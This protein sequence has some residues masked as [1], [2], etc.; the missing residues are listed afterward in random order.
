M[1]DLSGRHALVT[2]SNAGIG[3]AA[4]SLLARHG[5]AV[6][7]CARRLDKLADA[8]ATIE[9]AGGRAF[10]T[11][12][13]VSAPESITTA[14]TASVTALGPVDILVNNAG[15][16]L[17]TSLVE[18]TTDD[19]DRLIDTNLRG[20]WLCAREVAQRAIR[21]ERPA[22]IVNIASV[23]GIM[24]Q[25]GTGPYASSKAGLLHL[26][27]VMASEWARHRI[28]VNAIAPGYITTDMAEDFLATERGRR[29]LAAIP[30]RRIGTVDDLAGA[31][32]LLC[33]DASAYMTGSTITV[34]G[35]I[36]LGSN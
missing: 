24:T 30:Q 9:R 22:V 17:A 4:A 13:D 1:F 2:G 21:A 34:D 3:L 10:A 15:I 25:K 26:T 20:A 31:L 27:R 29:L 12:M 18:T 28:R 11:A 6:S 14:V 23:L 35:G 33:S 5:A 32:L 8:R 36:T 7:L 16:S 19:W